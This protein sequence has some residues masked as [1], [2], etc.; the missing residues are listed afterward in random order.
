MIGKKNTAIVLIIAIA[1]TG[2]GITV[3]ASIPSSISDII[4]SNFDDQKALETAKAS[5]TDTDI[6]TKLG[7]QTHNVNIP[8]G[9]FCYALNM[10]EDCYDPND[11]V[12]SVGDTVVWTNT[13][14]GVDH[15]VTSGDQSVDLDTIGVDYPNGFDSLFMPV[16][17]KFPVT[18][19][20]PGTHPYFCTE[21]PEMTGTI[22]VV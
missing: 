15:T 22:V 16:N 12:I 17:D 2:I 5:N 14:E 18:F 1:I 9:V 21:H 8:D 4:T 13:D 7:A 3:L 10:Q 20:V 19:D 11:I 6:G